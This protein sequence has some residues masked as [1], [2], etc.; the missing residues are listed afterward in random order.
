VTTL[1]RQTIP[2][3]AGAAKQKTKNKKLQTKNHKQKTTNKKP[4]TT[5]HKQK[6][7]NKK[8]QTKN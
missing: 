6:T 5:N 4:Q 3:E 8:L 2:H 7:K 1:E